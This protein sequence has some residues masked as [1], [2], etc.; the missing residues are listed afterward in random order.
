LASSLAS[1]L[2]YEVRGRD[3]LARADW[4][5]AVA[6]FRTGISLAG[7]TPQLQSVLH[8]QLGT[9]LYQQGDPRGAL[10]EFQEA[11]RWLPESAKA[12]YS[13]GVLMESVGRHQQ[14]IEHFETAVKSDPSYVEAHL[15]LARVL[16]QSGRLAEAQRQYA[17][18][19]AIDPRMAV[20]K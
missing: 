16:Q 6:A 18:A 7:N 1:A 17:E 20:T 4:N 15:Q 19:A 2:S 11:V 10:D 9:A 12:H 8:Q 5:G 3:A 13:I 14:A